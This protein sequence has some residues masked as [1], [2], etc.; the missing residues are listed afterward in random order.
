MSKRN[1]RKT[2]VNMPKR[3]VLTVAL[4]AAQAVWALPSQDVSQKELEQKME[5]LEAKRGVDITLDVKSEYLNARMDPTQ[6]PRGDSTFNKENVGF[7]QL[8][9]GFVFR[10]WEQTS[11]KIILRLASDYQ[12]FFNAGAKQISIPWMSIDGKVGNAPWLVYNVGDFRQKFSPLT[13]YSHEIAVPNE[14]E[15]FA[16]QRYMAMDQLFLGDNDRLLQGANVS[17]SKSFG[18]YFSPKADLIA[19]SLR[20]P[21]YLDGDGAGGFLIPNKEGTGLNSNMHKFAMGLNT[22]LFTLNENVFIGGTYLSNFDTKSSRTD[23]PI[24]TIDPVDEY[25][26]VF[27]DQDTIPENVTVSSFR[28]GVDIAGLLKLKSLSLDLTAELANSKWDLNGVDQED[29][30]AMLL[31]A[32][33]GF[34]PNDGKL[35]GIH[36]NTK[37]VNNDE[38][39]FNPLAQSPSFVPTRIMNSDKDASWVKYGVFGSYYSA[40]DAISHYSPK[41]SPASANLVPAEL[42]NGTQMTESYHIAPYSKNSYRNGVYENDEINLMR[43]L[44]DPAV[45]GA[46]DLGL[47]TPNRTGFILDGVIGLF[48]NS[49]ELAGSALQ[50]K[51][52]QGDGKYSEISGG[53]RADVLGILGN[54]NGKKLELLGGYT[55]INQ[56]DLVANGEFSWINFGFNWRFHP[57]VGIQAGYQQLNQQYWDAR[58]Y[59]VLGESVNPFVYLSNDIYQAEVHRTTWFDE[60]ESKRW[61]VGMEYYLGK[62]AWVALNYGQELVEN[63]Y[64]IEFQQESGT[65]AIKQFVHQFDKN[66]IEASI[67]VEF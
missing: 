49:V 37:F 36:L 30:G 23:V 54:A 14:A 52:V 2:G 29:G 19:T 61:L 66:L 67:S 47:A 39:F 41:F 10:P 9:L 26:S 1:I 6:S 33:I 55:L 51:E 17:F 8:D 7:T 63:T 31:D 62:N 58:K 60:G 15:I 64:N 11:A 16:R 34:S 53:L 13:L 3:I 32:N 24:D 57:R 20:R 44:R 40:F 12:V 59:T 46:M 38:H 28:A 22:D 5:R 42:Y 45:Q 48:E 35:F 4:L 21:E 27:V 25:R 43:S 50:M 65:Y 56:D 18:E